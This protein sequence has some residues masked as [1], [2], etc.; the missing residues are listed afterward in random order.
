[1]LGSRQLFAVEVHWRRTLVQY[2]FI[3]L[4]LAAIAEK[5]KVSD[6]TMLNIVEKV[7]SIMIFLHYQRPR[8][9]SLLHQN[10]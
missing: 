5:V 10:Y 3:V 6:T 4:S 8:P 1:M 9:V 7:C 2:I